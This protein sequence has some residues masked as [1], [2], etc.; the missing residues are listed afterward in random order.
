MSTTTTTN[1]D[2]TSN[3]YVQNVVRHQCAIKLQSIV[4]RFLIRCH[5]HK[6]VLDR[7][8]KIW[9][10]V[11]KSYYY[12]DILLDQ[13]S[14]YKPAI[15]L[16]SDITK[17]APTYTNDHAATLIQ[18]HMKR[19]FALRRVRRLY[20]ILIKEYFDEESQR[21]YYHNERTSMV[22]WFLPTFM[23]G[24]LDHN[25]PKN[26]YKKKKVIE[27]PKEDVMKDEISETSSK[28]KHHD[29]SD[30]DS[31]TESNLSE[32]SEE[33]R[34][35]RRL[36]RKKPR[37]KI[38]SKVDYCEDNWGQTELDLTGFGTDRITN[39]VYDL[40]TLESLTL[41][42]NFLKYI[43]PN[44]QYLLNLKVLDISN[45]WIQTFPKQFEE[46][47]ECR[48]LN[49]SRNFITGFPLYFYKMLALEELDLSYN[50]LKEMPIGNGNLELLK[51]LNVFDVG[52]GVLTNMVSLDLKSNKLTS[53]PLQ[54]E[55]LTKLQKLDLSYNKIIGS[56][57]PSLG[58]H[59]ELSY[60][61]LSH[62]TIVD[63]PTDFYLVPLMYVDLSYNMLMD[64]P[65]YE[66][67]DPDE[68]A[69]LKL[70]T[71]IHLDLSHNLI[72][73]LDMR[74]GMFPKLQM[75]NLSKN[76]L[77]NI[78]DAPFGS[79]TSL[80]RLDLS[81]NKIVTLPDSIGWIKAVTYAN[82]SENEI[83]KMPSSMSQLKNLKELYFSHNQLTELV[84]TTMVMLSQLQ[85]LNVSHNK[86]SSLP[87][88]LYQCKKLTVLDLSF[89]NCEGF[90]SA[91]GQLVE[92]TQL[93]AERN[94]ITTIPSSISSLKQ[95]HTA[96]LQRNCLSSLP[97]ELAGL[98]KLRCLRLSHNDFETCPQVLPKM[99]LST[100]DL[101]WSSR[102]K[103]QF[104][105]WQ[106]EDAS[107]NQDTDFI[108]IG[109]LKRLAGQGWA[110]LQKLNSKLDDNETFMSSDDETFELSSKATLSFQILLDEALSTRRRYYYNIQKLKREGF[111][112]KSDNLFVQRMK[113]NKAPSAPSHHIQDTVDAETKRMSLKLFM[114]VKNLKLD[115][116][117]ECTSPPKID[118][119][120]ID[121]LRSLDLGHH[122]QNPIDIFMK[123]AHELAAL[124]LSLRR[125]ERYA[126]ARKKELEEREKERQ[127]KLK[128]AKEKRIA[129]MNMNMNMSMSIK[130]PPSG[131]IKGTP[132][133]K[134]A[135]K[136]AVKSLS[137]VKA[138][139]G[140]LSKHEGG[141]GVVDGNS[142]G[143]D[144]QSNSSLQQNEEREE[145]EESSNVD[146]EKEIELKALA[147][148]DT[149][150]STANNNDESQLKKAVVTNFLNLPPIF[151]SNR[152]GERG[153]AMYDAA[154][155]I[156]FGLGSSLVSKVERYSDAIRKVEK[157]A[158]LEMSVLG[159]HCRTKG[160]LEDLVMDMY[161]DIKG[162]LS[163]SLETKARTAAL[164]ATKS[165]WD[166]VTADMDVNMIDDDGGDAADTPHDSKRGGGSE[167]DRDTHGKRAKKKKDAN[168]DKK[169]K[170]VEPKEVT[171]TSIEPET[172]TTTSND[173]DG[174]GGGK[175]SKEV[176]R[177][178]VSFLF[179]HRQNLLIFCNAALDAASE[180]LKMR[181]WDPTC[182][183]FVT[184]A[185]AIVGTADIEKDSPL[186]RER[187]T[188][189]GEIRARSLQWTAKF[190]AALAEYYGVIKMCKPI[191]PRRIKIELIKIYNAL[192][193]H[194]KANEI[195]TELILREMP[196]ATEEKFPPLY[197]IVKW[198][199]EL[200]L[201]FMY[202]Q[203]NLD[204][205]DSNNV[206]SKQ[207]TVSFNPGDDGMFIKL[208][209]LCKSDKVGR[210][211][212]YLAG[213]Y[214]DSVDKRTN[215][216]HENKEREEAVDEERVR[217]GN[218]IKKYKKILDK[219]QDDCEK[220]LQRVKEKEERLKSKK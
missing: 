180:L 115:L 155:E 97:M 167:G 174:E 187:A 30:S 46:L 36:L 159:I 144:D 150:N 135:L 196:E 203:V 188:R 116:T 69:A 134:L 185:S 192:G 179:Y 64:M 55:N 161:E 219:C 172:V 132:G 131:P 32:N 61:D 29:G 21:P 114:L 82:F 164:Q 12:Y 106:A 160:D 109:T 121:A 158:H 48:S 183:R 60:L 40:T 120:L 68:V 173:D 122:Y 76:K 56:V 151:N 13:S 200:G 38:Q 100:W 140:N 10:P 163:S 141:D 41:K 152:M 218:V 181:G 75:L 65:K 165:Q 102:F 197:D 216:Y 86:L 207:Q 118:K 74:I 206:R 139:G 83:Q 133:K 89:N 18:K 14:W 119:K 57:P 176:A 92:L 59:K 3:D 99:N 15:L 104:I 67:E 94:K 149:D 81:K 42:G 108:P 84:G 208:P 175:M 85:V 44:I 125:T 130:Q 205:L 52:I 189:L 1:F 112:M 31:D 43:H 129:N 201:L 54:L 49:A 2:P 170:K 71:F 45:N 128:E 11:R 204:Q 193:Q 105:D 23:K 6:L 66:T 111:S 217:L 126:L 62:N 157:E 27:I 70:E 153:S 113:T 213:S 184:S 138:L 37:S 199:E 168:N 4:K 96:E 88:A 154:F 123:A 214:F 202:A 53:W 35:K 169:K 5:I 50:L 211:L 107:Y 51:V 127:K 212:F 79:L 26:Y 95:L 101:S 8:E 178:V 117:S 182:P 58:V 7:Y 198:N 110:E 143:N 137:A 17:I 24:R 33:A 25:Y 103:G 72:P 191:R 195:T 9:D 220:D 19:H 166:I 87:L 190:N 156:Y 124:A 209:S 22:F 39:R 90:D 34:E 16:N 20:K 98:S 77:I 91:L 210:S 136:G 171:T 63:I 146:D 73:S 215:E 148:G 162:K 47:R 28:K 93:L 147:L 78:T 194:Y 142:T 80:T 186:L 145:G 177:R